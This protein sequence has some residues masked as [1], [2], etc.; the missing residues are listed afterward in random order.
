MRLPQAFQSVVAIIVLAVAGTAAA[1]S[2]FRIS[3]VFSNLDGSIQY[4]SLTE[5]AGL[6]NQ[7]LFN[8]L[9]LT[10]THAGVVKQF[11]FYDNLATFRTAN[12]TIV[13]AATPDVVP[14]R[15]SATTTA[16]SSYWRTRTSWFPHAS[17]RPTAGR[18]TSRAS[19]R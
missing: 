18:S 10:I 5:T 12:L 1:Q 8:G 11:V 2:T 16:I 4:V 9:T 17:S 3:Q 15:R 7:G 14:R 19:T 13:V 6:D